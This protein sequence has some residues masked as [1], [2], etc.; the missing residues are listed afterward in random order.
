MVGLAIEHN[1]QVNDGPLTS[2]NATLLRPS[3]PSL[4]LDELRARYEQDGYLFLKH[5]LPREDVLEARRQY[6]SLL[7]PTQSKASS[8]PPSRPMSTPASVPAR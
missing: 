2:E 3:D 5:L 6:F 4:P 8:T 7:A 1:I